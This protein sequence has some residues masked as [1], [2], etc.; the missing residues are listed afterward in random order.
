[1]K[2]EELIKK[3]G[4]AETAKTRWYKLNKEV[5]ENC[6]HPEEYLKPK[7]EYYEGGHMDTA[8]TEYWDECTICG[9]H[10]NKKTKD[11]GWYG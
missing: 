11:H 7:S 9:R 3:K 8:H 6:H 1:M 2:T 5:Y 4:Q 10:F